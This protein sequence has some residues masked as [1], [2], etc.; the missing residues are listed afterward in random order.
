MAPGRRS[1]KRLSTPRRRAAAAERD[2]REAERLARRTK[3]IRMRLE[4]HDFATIA[5]ACGYGSR[6]AACDDYHRAFDAIAAENEATT[7]QARRV[8][9]ARLDKL[10]TIAWAKTGDPEPAIALKAVETVLKI[11]AHRAR[12]LGLDQPVKHEI[13]FDAVE[14]RIA[15]LQ[16]FLDAHG[17]GDD[18]PDAD[19]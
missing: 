12:M 11:S 17:D 5:D 10:Q 1:G 13:S 14:A 3:C 6:Q 16:A 19:A 15:E 8:E 18:E 4:G 7:E 9:L 2:Q